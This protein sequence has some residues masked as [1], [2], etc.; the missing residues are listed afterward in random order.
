MKRE[1]EEEKRGCMAARHAVASLSCYVRRSQ[2]GWLI[3]PLPEQISSGVIWLASNGGLEKTTP[4]SKWTFIK[5]VSPVDTKWQLFRKCL[6]IYVHV[7]RVAVGRRSLFILRYVPA[8]I[9]AFQR[10][11]E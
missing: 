3:R 7:G 9:S 5:D 6:V 8:R 1:E 2:H 4:K 10:M 11:H